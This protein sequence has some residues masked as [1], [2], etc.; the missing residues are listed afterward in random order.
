M[1]TVVTAI[2]GVVLAAGTVIGIVASTN[3]GDRPTPQSPLST[4]QAYGSR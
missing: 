1:T 2:V 3:S 4:V